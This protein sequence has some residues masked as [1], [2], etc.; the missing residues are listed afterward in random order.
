MSPRRSSPYYSISNISGTAVLC[1]GAIAAATAVYWY[2]NNSKKD[3]SVALTSRPKFHV[4]FVLGGPGSGK[5]T[6]CALITKQYQSW[7]HLSA[8]DLLRAARN[9]PSNPI[10]AELNEY[11]S[12]GKLVPSH[13]T[14]ALI[15]QA[16]TISY[17]ETGTTHFLIDGY[18]RNQANVDVW[19]DTTTSFLSPPKM[20]AVIDFVLYFACPDEVLVDRLQERGKTSGRVDDSN[21]D[22]IRQ[23]IKTY[24]D[25]SFPIISSYQQQY[26]QY[27][28]DQNNSDSFEL[29]SSS[30]T[31][32]PRLI[33]IRADQTVENVF[34]EAAS[35]FV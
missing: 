32:P 4:V 30:A 12:T 3:R 8:G 34:R 11:I 31:A 20:H 1:C 5:G 15:Q 2:C 10:G 19:I 14:C 27:T 25:E 22:V 24:H 28:L 29:S 6:Q 33:T 16:M 21:L 26:Q 35:Y 23:R 7:K 17:Q 9:D 18:P 13:V